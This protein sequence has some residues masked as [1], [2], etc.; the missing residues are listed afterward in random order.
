[1][2]Y[3]KSMIESSEKAHLNSLYQWGGT[4]KPN[5]STPF[6]KKLN[7]QVLNGS[8]MM[9]INKIAGIKQALITTVM[10]PLLKW[11]S[12]ISYGLASFV[13]LLIALG[14]ISIGRFYDAK[15]K[16]NDA[17]DEFRAAIYFSGAT[18][19]NLF[20]EGAK[21]YTR[22]IETMS[23]IFTGTN[24]TPD[25]S[26]TT[27]L[28]DILGVSPDKLEI[29]YANTDWAAD[30]Q[31]NIEKITLLS[32]WNIMGFEPK[33]DNIKACY[34]V[35]SE[36]TIHNHLPNDLNRFT[37]ESKSDLLNG[38]VFTNQRITFSDTNCIL[39]V[40]NDISY[41]PSLLNAE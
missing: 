34:L 8:L 36:T 1:M 38:S 13:T 19:L 18:W 27:K 35:R 15:I 23:D 20:R 25:T 24:D 32:S 26:W 16:F 11:K 37:R 28:L 22:S 33:L 39:P 30:I 12:A 40:T 41:T 4:A 14:H 31:L 17:K 3:L 7:E 29:K 6:G 5:Y 9:M 10:L 21:L 2:T